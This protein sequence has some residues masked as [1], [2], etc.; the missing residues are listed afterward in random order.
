MCSLANST[1]KNCCHLS[2][3]I[4]VHLGITGRENEMTLGAT[5]DSVFAI[6]KWLGTPLFW[7]ILA[8]NHP[9]GVFTLADG[10][11]FLLGILN[12]KS[13]VFLWSSG[14][15]RQGWLPNQLQF[16]S[17]NW[18]AKRCRV[19][20]F[21]LIWLGRSWPNFPHFRSKKICKLPWW[22]VP[23]ISRDWLAPMTW[24]CPRRRR[25]FDKSTPFF[26][27]ASVHLGQRNYEM[28]CPCHCFR[29]WLW[30]HVWQWSQPAKCVFPKTKI[31][32]WRKML[33]CRMPIVLKLFEHLD[34][35]EA[36]SWPA[37]VFVRQVLPS[38][39]SGM[40]EWLGRFKSIFLL[41]PKFDLIRLGTCKPCAWFW[42][43]FLVWTLLAVST[44][45]SSRFFWAYEEH[46]NTKRTEFCA[47]WSAG[48]SRR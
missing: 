25:E 48:D 24:P 27:F 26:F 40:H 37:V 36:T 47:K 2:T 14:K 23:N 22:A 10:Q 12:I 13:G 34:Q 5:A 33:P 28:H 46:L 45:H 17:L 1:A 41:R 30:C 32:S 39:G 29:L 9:L 20:P 11:F 15:P 7:G 8:L 35:S 19:G 6:R 18:L 16:A 42:K 4:D 31:I 38:V 44:R 43:Q 3:S 21:F